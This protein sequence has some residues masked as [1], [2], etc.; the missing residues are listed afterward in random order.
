MALPHLSAVAPSAD[1]D[2]TI[3]HRPS[4]HCVRREKW[5][6][7]WGEQQQEGPVSSLLLRRPLPFILGTCFH[8]LFPHSLLA[9]YNPTILAA[10]GVCTERRSIWLCFPERGLLALASRPWP[11]SLL[12]MKPFPSPE[13]L[14][15]ASCYSSFRGKFFFFDLLRIYSV[16]IHSPTHS[17]R[18]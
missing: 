14:F 13:P 1:P 17:S 9:I 11:C 15:G 3:D 18:K 8:L 6:W 10:L 2:L 4:Q 16:T 12:C 5:G 7:G